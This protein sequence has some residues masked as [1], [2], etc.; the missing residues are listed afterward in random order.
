MSTR[1]NC[2][3]GMGLYPLLTVVNL[4]MGVGYLLLGEG[5]SLEGRFLFLPYL[6]S[7]S[8]FLC[9]G[10]AWFDLASCGF[11]FGVLPG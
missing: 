9:L 8:G 5:I 2:T 7:V 3:Q 4:G 10:H 11:V 1:E 6:V